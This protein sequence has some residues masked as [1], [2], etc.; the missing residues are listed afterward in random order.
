MGWARGS[1]MKMAPEPTDTS[2]SIS[3]FGMVPEKAVQALGLSH[4]GG[5]VN[6]DLILSM[7]ANSSKRWRTREAEVEQLKMLL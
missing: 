2:H 7:K 1:S 3:K 5:Y 6:T 4:H